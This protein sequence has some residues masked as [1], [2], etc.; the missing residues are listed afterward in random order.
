M[1]VSEGL[2]VMLPLMRCDAN[3]IEARLGLARP[4]EKKGEQEAVFRRVLGETISQLVTQ[5]FT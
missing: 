1:V 3:Q 4:T 5:M 2:D